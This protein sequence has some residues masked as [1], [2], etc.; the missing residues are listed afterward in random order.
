MLTLNLNATLCTTNTPHA[1]FH[2]CYPS[3]HHPAR[4]M[5]DTFYLNSKSSSDYLSEKCSLESKIDSS[6]FNS[7][8]VIKNVLLNAKSNFSNYQETTKEKT[9]MHTQKQRLSKSGSIR[10]LDLHRP[11]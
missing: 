8:K 11:S 2:Q 6:F 1:S 9:R 4:Q 7:T 10:N 5:H 3:E